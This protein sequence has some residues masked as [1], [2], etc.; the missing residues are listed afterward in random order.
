MFYLTKKSAPVGFFY[1]DSMTNIDAY[2]TSN[3]K[4]MRKGN[5]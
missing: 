3:L 2:L 1:E 5:L 4:L